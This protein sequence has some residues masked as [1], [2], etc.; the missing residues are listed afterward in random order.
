M[1]IEMSAQS[2]HE[3]GPVDTNMEPSLR[4]SFHLQWRRNFLA[5]PLLRLPTELILEIFAHA[6]GLDEGD[7]PSL[8]YDNSSS[9]D[10]SGPTLLVLTSICHQ[11]REIGIASPQL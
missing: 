10:K 5:S 8:N 7:Q 6:I 1:E 4:H 2:G 3:I 9:S 11:L